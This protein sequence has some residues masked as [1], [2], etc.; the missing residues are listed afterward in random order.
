MHGSQCWTLDRGPN[1]TECEYEA[2]LVSFKNGSDQSLTCISRTFAFL[3]DIKLFPTPGTMVCQC[4]WFASSMRRSGTLRFVLLITSV[5]ERSLQTWMTGSQMLHLKSLLRELKSINILTFWVLFSVDLNS[6]YEIRNIFFLMD[7]QW[8]RNMHHLSW[9]NDNSQETLMWTPFSCGLL[10][11]VVRA[12][13]YLSYVQSPSCT[14]W[15]SDRYSSRTKWI[16]LGCSS[17]G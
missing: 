9:R 6:A 5:I 4:T 1:V 16:T 2:I 15:R 12:T 17:T 10:A 14:P 3:I 8:R 11:I 7:M 13:T